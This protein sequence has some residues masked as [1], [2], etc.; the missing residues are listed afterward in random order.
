MG[1][2]SY[3][4]LRAPGFPLDQPQRDNVLPDLDIPLKVYSNICDL[5]RPDCRKV[6]QV[7]GYG[8]DLQAALFHLLLLSQDQRSDGEC[9]R[10]P[11]RL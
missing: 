6:G 10:L 8:C 11:V 1:S 7:D 3:Q 4:D 9:N 2:E 5:Q